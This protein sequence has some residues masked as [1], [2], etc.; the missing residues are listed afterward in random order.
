MYFF[1]EIYQ[2]ETVGAK[3]RALVPV[4]GGLVELFVAKHVMHFSYFSPSSSLPRF[5]YIKFLTSWLLLIL[6]FTPSE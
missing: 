5:L 6:K 2:Q 1:I 4:P 3:T